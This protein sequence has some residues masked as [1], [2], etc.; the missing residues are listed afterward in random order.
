MSLNDIIQKIREDATSETSAI[1]HEAENRAQDILSQGRAE[2][3]ETIEKLERDNE[4][5]IEGMKKKMLS[6]ARREVRHREMR[7]KEEV[8][9]DCFAQAKKSF[10][11]LTGDKYASVVKKL[12]RQSMPL[13]KKPVVVPSRD[14]DKKIARE[15]GLE[16][17][18]KKIAGVGGVIIREKDGSM[19]IDNTFEGLM[20]RKREDIRIKIAK[21][22]FK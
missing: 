9:T 5:T 2:A 3:C 21:K 4:K 18:S 20:A 15:L 7:A 19:E 10:A 16:T 13:L 1:I 11:S 17:A 12:I 22:L 8:I 14:M 6:G